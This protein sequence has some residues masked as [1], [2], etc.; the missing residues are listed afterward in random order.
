MYVDG[1]CGAQGGSQTWSGAGSPVPPR[2]VN[3]LPGKTV[4][5]WEEKPA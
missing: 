3:H 1:H 4:G 2:N 5:S